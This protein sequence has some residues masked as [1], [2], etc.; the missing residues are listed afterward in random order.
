[1]PGRSSGRGTRTS[2]W[3]RARRGTGWPL[4]RPF[5]A[6]SPRGRGV[7]SSACRARGSVLGPWSAGRAPP[8]GRSAFS[9]WGEG[10]RRPDEGGDGEARA[11]PSSAPSGHLLPTGR[12]EGRAEACRVHGR[13]AALPLTGGAPSPHGEKVAEGRMRAE[14][15]GAGWPLIRPFGAP[16]PR[17]AGRRA[18]GSV[19]GPWSQA[20]FPLSGGAPS[21][22]G[23]EGGRRPDEG[24]AARCGWTLIRPFGAPSPRRA[25]RRARGS[26]LG[27]WPAGRAPPVGRSAFS[28]WG[29]VREAG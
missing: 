8:V 9:P 7:A 16:S 5:G 27:P 23:G 20:V 18:R 14:R 17:R 13:Q 21:P 1:M 24:G 25:G 11:G 2:P 3:G 10:G 29:E 12:G 6:P 19:L 4:I 28:P 26:V 15:R 22:H